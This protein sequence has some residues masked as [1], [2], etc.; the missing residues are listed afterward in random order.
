M[1]IAVW[2]RDWLLDSGPVI[3]TV[4]TMLSRKEEE[5]FGSFAASAASQPRET[6]RSL[7]YAEAL[8]AGDSPP[9][10]L[11]SPVPLAAASTDTVQQPQGFQRQRNVI[12]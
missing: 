2:E 5:V 11:E 12:Q 3:G 7:G 10:F 9:P 8:K 6:F 1:Q 4:T